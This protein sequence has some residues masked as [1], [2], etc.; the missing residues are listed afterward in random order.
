M[1]WRFK[2][3]REIEMENYNDFNELFNAQSDVKKDVTIFNDDGSVKYPLPFSLT[4]DL[5]KPEGN[6]YAVIGTISSIMKEFGCSKADI[7]AFCKECTSSKSHDEFME[8]C[9]KWIDVEFVQ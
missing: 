5:T 1:V 9:K 3:E 8:V 4:I 6:S 2:T 7:D